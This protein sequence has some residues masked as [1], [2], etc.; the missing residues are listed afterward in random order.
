MENVKGSP[1]YISLTGGKD[2]ASLFAC[3]RLPQS[4]INREFFFFFLHL[5]FPVLLKVT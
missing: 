1:E 5:I 3:G 2:L 4:F